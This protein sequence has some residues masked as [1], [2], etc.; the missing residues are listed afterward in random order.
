MFIQQLVCGVFLAFIST[1]ALAQGPLVDSPLPALTIADRGELLMEKGDFSFRP[2]STEHNPGKVHIVQYF[3][4][5]KVIA[6][7]SNRLLICY[8]TVLELANTM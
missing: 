4:A 2:W 7:C 8:R 5:T 3:G 6:S 1:L